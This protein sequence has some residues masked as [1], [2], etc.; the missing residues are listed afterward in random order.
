MKNIIYFFLLSPFCLFSQNVGIGT[1][2]PS[3]KLEV[4]GIIFTSQGGVKFPDGSVQTTAYIQNG[5]MM[6]TGLSGLVI[7]FERSANI[8]GPAIAPLITDGINVHSVQSGLGVAVSIGGG[9]GGQVSSPNFSEITFS[10]IADK[11]SSTLRFL[12]AIGQRIPYIEVFYLQLTANGHRI[13]Q[14]AK[15]E[16]C[17]LSGYSISSGGDIPS[18]SI[19]F[20]FEK[21]C[22]RSYE[23][24]ESGSP[25]I[26]DKCWNRLTNTGEA[27]C[28]CSF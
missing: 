9:G 16:G 21:A 4:N 14:A 24:P 6:E 19:S 12:V 3:E 11:N 8:K 17:Y 15:Y 26:V 10:R 2:N 22:Y 5:N 20:A 27:S 25:V 23:Y 18:E 28:G 1:T 13:V 7:E